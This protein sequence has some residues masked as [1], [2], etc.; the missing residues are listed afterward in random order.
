MQKLAREKFEKMVEEGIRAIPEKFL[1]LLDNVAIVI[2]EEPTPTQKK[3]E[4]QE[5]V[6]DTVWHEIA[7]HFGFDE[8]GVRAAEQKR[9]KTR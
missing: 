5:A 1:R 3:E 2:E 8:K 7:H 6:R 9:K 4:I